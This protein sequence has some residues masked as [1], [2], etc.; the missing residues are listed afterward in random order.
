MTRPKFSLVVTT[1]NRSHLVGGA[2]ESLLRQTESDFE[3]V[4][5]NND[6]SEQ[7]TEVINNYQDPRIRHI[8][9]GGL[10]MP[11]NWR[12]GL[13][14]ANGEWVI[15]VEEKYRIKRNALEILSYYIERN[16]CETITWLTV[17]DWK[18][19]KGPD[20]YVTYSK[21]EELD[22]HEYL[23]HVANGESNKYFDVIPKL[24][25]CAIKRSLINTINGINL[26]GLC[27]PICCDLTSAFSILAHTK[28]FLYLNCSLS[29][30]PPNSPS[31]G[32]ASYKRS[33]GHDKFIYDAGLTPE[34]SYRNVAVKYLSLQNIIYNDFA[35]MMNM[36][37]KTQEYPIDLPS[38]YRKLAEEAFGYIRNGT[39]FDDERALLQ[40]AFKAEPLNV[41]FK[42]LSK[43][44]KCSCV[45]FN[46]LSSSSWK[47]LGDC[48]RRNL[49][50]WGFLNSRNRGL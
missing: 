25:N 4:I 17:P 21:A 32:E 18:D 33:L 23:F 47:L 24:L 28:K 37:S 15:F 41:R 31:Q 45:G 12:R 26:K 22:S 19:S 34:Y 7:T 40:K 2:I 11:Q 29:M 13:D 9:T 46:G 42:T 49:L 6:D 14:E 38:Y 39:P 44:L 10:G 20:F 30:I 35:S 27:S 43:D 5:V 48:L 36:F 3:I 1:K 16:E 8:R 50:L